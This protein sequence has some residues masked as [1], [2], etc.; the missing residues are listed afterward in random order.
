M[1]SKH[2]LQE[3]DIY[4]LNFASPLQ[5]NHNLG[6]HVAFIYLVKAFDTANHDLLIEIHADDGVPPQFCDVVKCLYTDLK[7]V[8]K[9]GNLKEEI[10][11]SV[12]VHPGRQFSTSY[13]LVFVNSFAEYL[14][15]LFGS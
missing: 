12:G 10:A 13:F 7:V 5:Q 9:I 8:L 3:W 14:G 6:T 4:P 1:H 11:Q 15:R 2:R